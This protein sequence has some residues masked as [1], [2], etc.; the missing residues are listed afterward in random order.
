MMRLTCV[1]SYKYHNHA[2]GENQAASMR[3]G[4]AHEHAEERY[5]LRQPIF[6]RVP[7]A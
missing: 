3:R 7:S 1:E 4:N 6:R 5:R 2:A